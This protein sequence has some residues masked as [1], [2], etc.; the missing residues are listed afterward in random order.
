MSKRLRHVDPSVS[1]FKVSLLI[2]QCIYMYLFTMIPYEYFLL[3]NILDWFSACLI[4]W[5]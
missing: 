4:P 3:A 2:D 5:A 1:L